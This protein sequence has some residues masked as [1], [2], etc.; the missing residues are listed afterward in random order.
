M[1]VEHEKVNRPLAQLVVAPIPRQGEI[2]QVRR[3]AGRLPVMVTQD[4]PKH[5]G[6]GARS[7]CP[8]VRRDVAGVVLTD[9]LI[10]GGGAAESVVVVTDRHDKV[11]SPA[12]AEVVYARII[13]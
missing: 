8:F 13:R 1:A 3:G 4:R 11:R 5:I 2:V 10:D 9:I 6:G 7:V 12:L